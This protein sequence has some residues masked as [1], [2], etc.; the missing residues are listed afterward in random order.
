MH[1]LI[2]IAVILAALTTVSVTSCSNRDTLTA[3]AQSAMDGD[4]DAQLDLARRYFIGDGLS[5]DR[6]QAI[7]WFR[8]AAARQHPYGHYR[9][10]E[11]YEFGQGVPPDVKQAAEHYE[12]AA[13]LNSADAQDALARLYAGGALG[14]KDYL[15]GYVWYLLA[16]RHNNLMWQASDYGTGKHLNEKQKARAATAAQAIVAGFK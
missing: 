6:R 3:L 16:V 12:K 13:R 7:Y 8:A 14:A 11:A 2:A 5:R 15:S 4:T 1:S 10:G 9:L